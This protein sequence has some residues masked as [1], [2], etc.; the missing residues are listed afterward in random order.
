MSALC[1][2]ESPNG[3]ETQQSPAQRNHRED[4]AAGSFGNGEFRL[5]QLKI[6]NVRGS[7]MSA[8]VYLMG[9]I[10]LEIC[11]TLA[12][13]LSAGFEKWHWGLVSIGLYSAC[14]WALAP[15]LNVLPV[16][17]V[18]AIWAGVGIVGVSILG[19]LLFGDRL[20]VVNYGFMSMILL[21]AVGLKLT[22]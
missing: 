20:S 4:G 8:W 9:A 6:S 7:A 2:L 22:T 19:A 1:G 17:V 13:K 11:A 12:L 21:G 16:G 5:T 3:R 14:F 10:C 18:Y 15:A